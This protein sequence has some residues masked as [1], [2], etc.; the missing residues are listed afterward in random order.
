MVAAIDSTLPQ[1]SADVVL[2]VLVLINAVLGWRFGTL[3]RVV[4]FAGLYAGV[5]AATY[6]GNG[7]ASFFRHGDI[8]ANAWSFIAVATTVV[9]VFEV[10]GVIFAD[11]LERLANL[12]FDRVAGLVLGAAVGF[13]EASVLFMIAIAVGSAPAQAG[14]TIPASRDAAANAV[15]SASLSGQAV[16]AQGTVHTIF[17]PVLPDNLTTHLS[18]G[19]SIQVPGT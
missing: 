11:R 6:T 16:R 8:F 15:R 17:G 2:V 19:T 4:T 1:F 18:E 3:R 7:I 12:V 5:F 9:I 13:L 10:V 14:T